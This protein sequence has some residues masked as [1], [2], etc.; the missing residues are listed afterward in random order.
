[1]S[2][3][4]PDLGGLDLSLMLFGVCKDVTVEENNGAWHL[5]ALAPPHPSHEIEMDMGK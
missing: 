2:V 3:F 4:L 1:M 5:Q